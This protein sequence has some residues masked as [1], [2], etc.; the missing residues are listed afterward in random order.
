MESYTLFE[1]NE[2]VRRVIVLNFPESLWVNCEI[3]QLNES[4]GHYYFSLIEKSK[5]KE[6]VIAQSEA[7]L[8]AGKYRELRK[9]YKKLLDSLLQNGLA[10]LLKVK[11]NYDERYGLKLIIED[12]DP[13]YTVGQMELKRR[14][15][16][17]T[18]S[19]KGL[20]DLNGCLTLPPVIQNIAVISSSTAAGLQDYLDQLSDNAY[21]YQFNNRLFASAMQGP[22]V[23]KELLH[24]LKKI[25]Q[26]K[27]QYEAVVII[28]GGG[29]K[30][31]LSVFDNLKIGQ[32]IA[33]FPIPVFVGIGHE[34]DE[35]IIDKVAHTS[36]KT[37]TAVAEF[38]IQ[39]MLQYETGTLALLGRINQISSSIVNENQNQLNYLNKMIRVYGQHMLSEAVHHINQLQ[40]RIPLAGNN[41]LI[42][43]KKRLYQLEK[44][45]AIL[46]P[47]ATFKRGYSITTHKGKIVT[48]NE[49][50]TKGDILKSHLLSGSLKSIVTNDQKNN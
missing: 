23:E 16:L 19:N 37:P 6:V 48:R 26:T 10:V 28:R 2:Y 21:G 22:K 38:L 18:L 39:R 4:R 5:D 1:L 24:Q 9:K 49:Q 36:L 43:E 25:A 46:A 15:I 41:Q 7:T 42:L 33:G 31:D 20:L 12:I 17:D 13:G 35:T 11:V 45:C 8:W 32:A 50:V 44:I 40:R 30:L 29:S 3:A 14:E 34:I 27:Y 47:E